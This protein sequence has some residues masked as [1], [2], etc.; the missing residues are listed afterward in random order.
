MTNKA[1]KSLSVFKGR[2]GFLFKWKVYVL[3][4]MFGILEVLV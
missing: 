1:L 2:G 3:S 4:D